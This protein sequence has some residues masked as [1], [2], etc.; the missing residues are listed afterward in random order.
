MAV[1]AATLTVL[2]ENTAGRAGLRGEWG[3]SV[4]IDTGQ[5]RVLFDAGEATACAHNAREMGVDLSAADAVVL[6]HGHYDHT[7]GL[8]EVLPLLPRVPIYLHPGTL[9]SRYAKAGDISVNPSEVRDIGMPAAAR[10]H[11]ENADLRYVEAPTEVVP[12]IWT[13]GAIPRL[14]PTEGP[15]GVG[16]LDPG[17]TQPDPVVDDMAVWLETEAGILIVLGCA[18]A[19]VINTVRLVETMKRGLP[20]T[21]LIGGTHLRAVSPERMEATIE[22][23]RTLPLSM[24]AACHCTGPKEAFQLQTAFPEQF[25][26]M[27][28]GSILRFPLATAS[29]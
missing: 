11:L 28:A 4:W 16:A 25:V 15:G 10:A 2:C 7:G 18:H 21:G 12:G 3:L 5:H 14:D 23:L 26:P 6:S 20:I 13:T 27:N 19:G 9:Q 29:S 22:C 17:L 24:L 1:A 8:A